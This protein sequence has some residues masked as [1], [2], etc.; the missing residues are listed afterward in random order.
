MHDL[1]M[2]GAWLDNHAWLL[3]DQTSLTL[4]ES[5]PLVTLST[6]MN[7][8]SNSASLGKDDAVL[9]QKVLESAGPFLH[10]MHRHRKGN[11]KKLSSSNVILEDPYHSP[12][13][14]SP[15]RRIPTIQVGKKQ[16]TNVIGFGGPQRP[17]RPAWPGPQRQNAT[18]ASKSASRLGSNCSIS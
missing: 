3:E 4:K 7:S 15:R 1:A 6:P 12:A 11:T 8:D 2:L 9:L 13:M 18:Q 16:A 5:Q 17:P 10:E 14:H